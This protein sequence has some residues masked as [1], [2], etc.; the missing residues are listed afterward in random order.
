MA[1]PTAGSQLIV[2]V[3]SDAVRDAGLAP[4]DID[5]VYLGTFNGGFVRQEFP[6]SLV[7]QAA[8]AYRFSGQS[9]ASESLPF[10]SAFPE[11]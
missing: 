3:A 6:A 10:S 7:F 5:A 8:P 9:L 2:R 11:A 1:R 4:A